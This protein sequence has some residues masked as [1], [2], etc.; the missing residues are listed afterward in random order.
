MI[1]DE[2]AVVDRVYNIEF[3]PVSRNAKVILPEKLLAPLTEELVEFRDRLT[4][5]KLQGEKLTT[6]EMEV[7]ARINARFI[8]AYELDTSRLPSEV[9]EAI[10]EVRR[11]NRI[12][13]T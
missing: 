6:L 1:A 8:R 4:F 3:D 7:L 9:L 12:K 13:S 11:L 10:E 5:R 2:D